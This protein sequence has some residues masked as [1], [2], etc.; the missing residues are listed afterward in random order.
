[1][2]WIVT[3]WLP[4]SPAFWFSSLVMPCIVTHWLPEYPLRPCRFVINRSW[5]PNWQSVRSAVRPHLNS[6]VCP[7]QQPSH[8]QQE[9]T[10]SRPPPGTQ[11]TS[12]TPTKSPY[13]GNHCITPWRK[14]FFKLSKISLILLEV[15]LSYDLKLNFSFS[16]LFSVQ[17]TLAANPNDQTHTISL[18]IVVKINFIYLIICSPG[19]VLYVGGETGT[20]HDNFQVIY[21][22]L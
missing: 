22:G 17:M 11:T 1:M 6:P 13:P 19:S 3:H 9:L 16:L 20:H 15:P 5:I 7:P 21:I 12:R 10:L 2:P 8:H 4:E 14:W 18:L